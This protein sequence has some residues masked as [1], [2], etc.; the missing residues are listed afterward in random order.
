MFFTISTISWYSYTHGFNKIYTCGGVRIDF[1]ASNQGRFLDERTFTLPIICHH[2][3]ICLHSTCGLNEF[4]FRLEGSVYLL[5]FFLRAA[6]TTFASLVFAHTINII[7][8]IATVIIVSNNYK[9]TTSSS[10]GKPQFCYIFYKAG[11]FPFP[12]ASF[13]W[14]MG[15]RTRDHSIAGLFGSLA[16]P[17]PRFASVFRRWH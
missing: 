11:C 2:Y 3:Y 1:G 7:I 17:L 12:I 13:S 10:V 6:R 15:I 16:I 9:Y 4:R 5:K 8:I 14:D